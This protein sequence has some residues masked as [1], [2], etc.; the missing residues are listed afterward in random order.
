MATIMSEP[1]VVF[2]VELLLDTI[3]Q[4]PVLYEKRN[5]DSPSVVLQIARTKV[6]DSAS[7]MDMT[8]SSPDLPQTE[9]LPSRSSSSKHK[10][11]LAPVVPDERHVREPYQTTIAS[12][13]TYVIPLHKVG[14]PDVAKEMRDQPEVNIVETL[15]W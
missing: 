7:V 2:S 4:H 15:C 12:N 8:I 3:K 6:K 11:A 13:V 14:H 10:Q 9:K 1:A 5:G